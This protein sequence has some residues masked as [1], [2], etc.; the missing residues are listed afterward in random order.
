MSPVVFLS[1]TFVGIAALP[2]NLG[3]SP[4]SNRF[5]VKS[6][7]KAAIDC[8]ACAGAKE[9]PRYNT[10]NTSSKCTGA[11]EITVIHGDAEILIMQE[12]WYLHRQRN[13][14]AF[15]IF[16]NQ[17]LLTTIF[18]L[19]RSNISLI[20]RDLGIRNRTERTDQLVVRFNA[21]TIRTD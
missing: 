12:H 8:H 11:F 4:D 6:D 16:F 2:G 1:S 20:D 9:V 3:A 18:C 19:Q 14:D 15:S 17:T 10:G 13:R 5:T 7:P 21:C